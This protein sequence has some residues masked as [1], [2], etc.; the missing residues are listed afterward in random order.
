MPRKHIKAANIE[1]ISNA[2]VTAR[3][4]AKHLDGYPDTLP[5][6][7][8]D[9]YS[10]QFLS[11][12]KWP[13]RIVGWKVGG[14]S[15]ETQKKHKETRLGGP[16]F[17]KQVYRT[18]N[19][20]GEF[21]MPVFEGGFA[22]IEDELILEVGETI[23]PG[24]VDDTKDDLK[25]LI[26]KVF[27]G[28]EIASSPLLTLNQLGPTSIISDFGN[29]YGVIVGQELKNWRNID[30]GK[31]PVRVEISNG[32]SAKA[33]AGSKAGGPLGALAFLIRH[34]ARYNITLEKGTLISS[35]AITG[36]HQSNIGDSSEIYY[37]DYDPIKL[38]LVKA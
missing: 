3:L 30:F 27:L 35:G 9:A 36:V 23:L 16:V 15:S 12:S 4:N 10:A 31:L 5:D 24:T 33:M 2:F 18:P 25:P 22:A 11:I 32:I 7:L 6:T 17:S 28:V 29:Q 38:R 34:F 13:D 26:S 1:K 19:E 21:V 8:D 37:G 20:K 14:I